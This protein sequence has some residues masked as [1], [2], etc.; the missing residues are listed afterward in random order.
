MTSIVEI[1]IVGSELPDREM[2]EPLEPDPTAKR[3]DD[4][5][6]RGGTDVFG[7]GVKFHLGLAGLRLS[8]SKGSVQ[9]ARVHVVA[10]GYAVVQVDVR[11]PGE[12][13]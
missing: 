4:E 2:R 1:R 13:L 9:V 5:K 3:Q 10:P 12:L 6:Q 7:E 8:V 11:C